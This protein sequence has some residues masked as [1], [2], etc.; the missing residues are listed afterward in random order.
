MR[1]FRKN[2]ILAVAIIAIAA[3]I[4]FL[5]TCK[6]TPKSEGSENAAVKVLSKA[7]KDLKYA[8]AKEIVSP[9]G[10][11]NTAG[12]TVG[13]Q[14][15]KKVVLVYFW[16]YSCINCQRTT[17]YLNAWQEK[18]ASAGLE[19]IGVHTPEFEFEKDYSN[20][21]KAVEKFGIKYPVVL[22][23]DCSTWTAYKNRYWHRK[24]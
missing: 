8:K 10:F 2:I 7:S 21:Q 5:Q 24:Y 14:I 3:V 17:P 19:I 11:I 9:A 13:E 18:Y 1:L 20:V 16:T 22:D 6:V 4:Y 12:I 23:N 15:G